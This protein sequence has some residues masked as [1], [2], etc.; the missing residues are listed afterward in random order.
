MHSIVAGLTGLVYNSPK[1]ED[2]HLIWPSSV[3]AL[4][5]N[6][7]ETYSG[8]KYTLIDPVPGTFLAIRKHLKKFKGKNKARRLAC[9]PSKSSYS[10]KYDG[11][12]LTYDASS[13]A[14]H[15]DKFEGKVDCIIPFFKLLKKGQSLRMFMINAYRER[16]NQAN[17]FP[18]LFDHQS[19]Y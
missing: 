15:L 5:G 7:V 3:I 14:M 11:L 13:H 6:V 4:T 18:C 16:L 12:T 19:N 1:H 2:G 8:S 17:R 9:F 10:I